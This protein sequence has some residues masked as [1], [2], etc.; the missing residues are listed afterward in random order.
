MYLAQ[1]L[2]L[3]LNMACI[4]RKIKIIMLKIAKYEPN[5][6]RILSGKAK[7]VISQQRNNS[8]KNSMHTFVG[9]PKVIR[10][11]Y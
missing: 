11:T 1:F 3:I 5:S 7:N 10:M 8:S 4:L 6:Y 2:V 9:P